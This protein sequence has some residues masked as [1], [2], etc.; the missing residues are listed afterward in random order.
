M[1]PMMGFC[2]FGMAL[3]IPWVDIAIF[4]KDLSETMYKQDSF[5][6]CSGNFCFLDRPIHNSICSSGVKPPF[7][8]QRRAV[9]S[10]RTL[11]LVAWG[12]DTHL[13]LCNATCPF[14]SRFA[15][16]RGPQKLDAYIG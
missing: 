1:G 4:F 9:A 12:R 11:L 8:E 6:A 2:T 10:K 13:D 16:N 5:L 7:P 15:L 3:R 14:I